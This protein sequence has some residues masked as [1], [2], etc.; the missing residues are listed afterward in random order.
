MKIYFCTLPGLK[1][2]YNVCRFGSCQSHVGTTPYSEFESSSLLCNITNVG[3]LHP[4]S[5]KDQISWRNFSH[6]K[7]DPSLHFE[8]QD[9]VQKSNLYQ[10]E[11]KDT[12]ISWILL[13]YK[14]ML[15]SQGL[16]HWTY[17]STMLTMF[18][19]SSGIGPVKLFLYSSLFVPSPPQSSNQYIVIPHLRM[20][21]EV[22]IGKFDLLEYLL[23]I[24]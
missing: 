23:A 20:S 7:D 12:T 15:L 2:T 6:F 21:I 17:I 11:I 24:H 5:F 9:C 19:H 14:F 8:I 4:T 13:M 18:R 1:G 3:P 16:E 10:I 22:F